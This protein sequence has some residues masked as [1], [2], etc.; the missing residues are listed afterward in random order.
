MEFELAN[1]SA[2]EV[3]SDLVSETEQERVS[4]WDLDSGLK[5]PEL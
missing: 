3:R 1:S 2:Q 4:A 5:V